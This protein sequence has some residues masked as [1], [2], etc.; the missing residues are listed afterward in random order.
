MLGSLWVTLITS[1][2]STKSSLSLEGIWAKMLIAT[3]R[4]I[5]WSHFHVKLQDTKWQS[6]TSF[7]SLS[8]IAL[9]YPFN[10]LI[11]SDFPLIFLVSCTWEIYGP[12]ECTGDW[13]REQVVI[14]LFPRSAQ[15]VSVPSHGLVLWGFV[16]KI[17]L[18]FGFPTQHR[19][20]IWLQTLVSLQNFIALS[21]A[22]LKLK[23]H[24]PHPPDL[25]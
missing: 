13:L 23:S 6:H 14:L 10:Y 18:W 19:V 9:C 20:Q 5:P 8:C 3:W 16:D 7:D 21:L 24:S 11:L 25:C 4:K 22:V 17:L 2:P 1:L 12:W 15:M